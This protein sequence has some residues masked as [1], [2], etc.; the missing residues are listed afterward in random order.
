MTYKS[1][2]WKSNHGKNLEKKKKGI[3]WTKGR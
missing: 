3:V 1:E 2:R